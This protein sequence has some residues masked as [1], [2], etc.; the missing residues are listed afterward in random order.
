MRY[1]P[2]ADCGSILVKWKSPF[3]ANCSFNATSFFKAKPGKG[4][5]T[6]VYRSTL[7]CLYVLIPPPPSPPMHLGFLLL[8]LRVSFLYSPENGEDWQ[9]S[10]IISDIGP[11]HYHSPNLRIRRIFVLIAWSQVTIGLTQYVVPN[12]IVIRGNYHES[13][14]CSEYPKNPC[15]NQAT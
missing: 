12:V 10:D 4:C 9:L 6:I 13:S 5:V 15:W 1:I 2:N 3:L 7:T 8:G 11:K 14:D